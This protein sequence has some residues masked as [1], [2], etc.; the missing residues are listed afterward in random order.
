MAHPTIVVTGA[1]GQVGKRPGATATVLARRRERDPGPGTR[2]TGGA[3]HFAG[4]GAQAVVGDLLSAEDRKRALDGASLVV[5]CRRDVPSGPRRRR[6]HVRGEPG[7]GRGAGR[8]ER[9]GRGATASCRSARTSSTARASA[10]RCARTRAARPHGGIGV[11]RRE[12]RGRGA[13][14][15]ER[16]RVPGST[17]S[18]CGSPSSTARVTRTSQNTGCASCSGMGGATEP[19]R[20]CT[21]RT[22][23]R[24]SAG[25]SGPTAS[26]VAPT[27]LR[28]TQRSRRLSSLP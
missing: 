22:S 1:T 11:R 15:S 28:T 21:T 24:P 4:L 19:W 20:W 10:G 7:R 9:S 14:A 3:E 13:I 27:T 2:G 18:R 5:N 8:A 16:A 12:A 23:P 26:P 25:R 6:R 17:W